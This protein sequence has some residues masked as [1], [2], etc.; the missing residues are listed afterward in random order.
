MTSICPRCSTPR[1]SDYPLCQTCGLDFRTLVYQGAP[2]SPYG[3]LPPPPPSPY[4]V[5]PAPG[6][7]YGAP[8]QPPSV[9]PRCGAPLYPGYARCG[10]CGFDSTQPAWGPAPIA[11][12]K[13]AG[14]TLLPIL[15]AIGGVVLLVASVV[16]AAGLIGVGKSSSSSPV[17][18]P[19]SAALASPKP[20]PI[21]IVV[22]PTPTEAATPADSATPEP[23]ASSTLA[24]STP[25]PSPPA[26]WT[27]FTA[28]DGKWSV[29][30]PTTMAPLKQTMPLNSGIAKGDMTMYW[31]ADRGTAY[32]MV[33]FDFPAGTIGTTS[34]SFLK[35]MES[36]MMASVGGTLLSSSDATVGAYPARD[37]TIDNSGQ[38]VNLRVWFVGDRFCMGMVAA[39][40]GSIVY[41]QHF[42]S[43]IVVGQTS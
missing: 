41:P 12:P 19:T 7:T 36:S 16:A 35:M 39:P 1:A 17:S 3:T 37:L 24:P 31:V 23:A 33:Y 13:P 8:P 32:A 29:D 9:C 25:E 26:A 30:F 18:V 21:V 40:A 5:P 11:A 28:P 38:M 42:M 22:T 15:L 14:S 6:S 43:T 10:N 34:S 20:T 2:A 4:G 27:T